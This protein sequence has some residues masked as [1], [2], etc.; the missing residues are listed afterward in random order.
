MSKEKEEEPI[1]ETLR[2]IFRDGVKAEQLR[3]KKIIESE[4]KKHREFTDKREFYFECDETENKSYVYGVG[5]VIGSTDGRTGKRTE[6]VLD[7]KEKA[8]AYTE[9]QHKK[10][11]NCCPT[12]D[13][14]RAII[15]K[16]EGDGK[17]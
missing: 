3:I 7:T 13:R 4:W 14:F 6:I 17:K 1:K 12:C 16:I 10:F 2:Q 8:K 11:D 9:A 15:K 5:A